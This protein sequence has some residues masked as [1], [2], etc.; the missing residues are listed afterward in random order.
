MS[1]LSNDLRAYDGKAVTLL[2]EA[3]VKH[4]ARPTYLAELV[5]LA[6]SDEAHVSDGATWLLKAGLEKGR[7]LKLKETKAL[8]GSLEVITSWPAQLHICQ[9]AHLL[10]VPQADAAAFAAWLGGLLGHK[11]PFL[12]A[13][14][15]SALVAVA[16]QH[17]AHAAQAEAAL[18][19]AREDPAASV[20]ARVRNVE[21]AS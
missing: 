18:Q 10:A 17:S 16:G 2:S 5:V 1:E 11:R 20:R 6:A 21:K 3:E 14:S 4:G 13:W 7:G 12:R 15:M 19:A 8:I 9:M